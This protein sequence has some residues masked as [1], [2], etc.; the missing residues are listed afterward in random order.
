MEDIA[1][2]AFHNFSTNATSNFFL[3][4]LASETPQGDMLAWSIVYQVTTTAQGYQVLWATVPQGGCVAAG[5]CVLQRAEPVPV[6]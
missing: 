6:D 3:L 4:S 1:Y 2:D 5:R